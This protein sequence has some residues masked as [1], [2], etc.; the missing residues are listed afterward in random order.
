[1]RLL[2]AGDFFPS[3]QVAD[4]FA[5][6]DFGTVFSGVK[7]VVSSADLA[8]VNLECPVG[9]SSPISKVG[10]ALRCGE[11]ALEA[12]KEAGYGC[13]SLA[14]N[15]IGDYGSEGVRNTLRK[16]K[17]CSLDYV[18]AGLDAADAS[19]ALVKEIGGVRVAIIN[20]C[21]TEFSIAGTASPGACALDPVEQYRMI[22]EAKKV[23]DKVVVIVHGGYERC[24]FP[25]PRMVRTYRFFIDAGAD[26]VLNHHQH[27]AS[28]YEV[29]SGKPIFYGL[30]NF[31][32]ATGNDEGRQWHEGYMV[33]LTL[34]KDATAP[35][36]RIIPY[37][38]CL[39]GQSVRLMSPDEE[40]AFR[41]RIAS[42]NDIIIDSEALQKAYG[43]FL[44][45]QA[46]VYGRVF[47][48]TGKVARFLASVGI[49]KPFLSERKRLM[50]K[51]YINCESHR[52]GLADYLGKD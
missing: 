8:V 35:S 42:L 5:K 49:L 6:K 21:E 10:P 31:C 34:D 20:C 37:V 1:M 51:N 7:E 30:G 13:V 45:Q 22:G 40:T 26:A 12:L 25:S 18:G 9:G 28:G 29:Y 41:E 47:A 27:C 11:E 17:E 44:D 4:L 33:M 24:P 2:I 14:N 16:V 43:G 39:D 32:F 50:L 3:A 52:E 38:Q 46:S 48:P 15:H 23:A 36:F 19:K